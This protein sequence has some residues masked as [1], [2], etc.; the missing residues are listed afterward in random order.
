[1]QEF[2]PISFKIMSRL[3][4]KHLKSDNT[5][6]ILGSRHRNHAHMGTLSIK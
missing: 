6:L 2:E 4:L 3:Q 5:Q 1:M